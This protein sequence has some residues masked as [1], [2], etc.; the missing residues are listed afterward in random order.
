MKSRLTREF[1]TWEEYV[2]ELSSRFGDSLYDDPMRELKSLKQSGSV[3]EYHDVFEELLNRV[4]LPKDYAT[5]CFLSGLK[6]EIQLILRMFMPKNVQHA[7]IL[8]KIEEA[9]MIVQSKEK[10]MSKS[11]LN[12]SDRTGTTQFRAHAPSHKWKTDSKAV[13]PQP[14]FPAL[15]NNERQQKS[16]AKKPFKR[17]STWF[18]D[19]A[20]TETTRPSRHRLG[21]G[22]DDTATNRDRDTRLAEKSAET[23]PRRVVTV[24][25]PR[26]IPSQGEFNKKSIEKKQK[27]N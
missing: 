15:P 2:R 22:R 1:P 9:K 12:Y 23:S 25:S 5:S 4:D 16:G 8:T 17:L 20:E 19:S 14:M 18:E 10:V 3:K 26:V 21:L 27:K 6:P 24:E 11:F 7:R 13:L